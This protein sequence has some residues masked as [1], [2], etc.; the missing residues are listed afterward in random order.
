MGVSFSPCFMF[1]LTEHGFSVSNLESIRLFDS[2]C[3]TQQIAETMS[4]EFPPGIV[5]E[6]DKHFMRLDVGVAAL[7]RVQTNF[8][9]Y[10]A[11]VR[12]AACEGCLVPPEPNSPKLAK[13]NPPSNLTKALLR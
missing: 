8:K 10:H 11:S 12:K 13:T 7:R 9:R 1:D 4:R 2:V 5:A 6:I 3:G